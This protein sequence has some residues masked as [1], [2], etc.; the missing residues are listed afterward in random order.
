MKKMIPILLC[1]FVLTAQQ[2]TAQSIPTVAEV[3]KLI[4]N[5]HLLVTYREGEVLYG[6]YYFIEIHYCPQGYG[7]Y[8]RTVKK[9]YWEMNSGVTGRSLE[10]G[11]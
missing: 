5:N 2:S 9:Q 7:L 11:K 4:S 6:T 1:Y 10:P 3:N 8:G